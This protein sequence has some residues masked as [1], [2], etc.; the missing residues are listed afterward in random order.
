MLLPQI[1]T[2][3]FLTG[4]ELNRNELFSL[5]EYATVLKKQR[6]QGQSAEHS[7]LLAGKT[8]ALLFE[9]QSLRT[10][11]SFAVAVQQLGGSAIECVTAHAK[12]E[13]PIDTIRV[14]AGYCDAV[15]WR[16]HAH[17]GL[18]KV[19]KKSPISVINGLSDTH[20]P[21]QALADLLT[22]QEKLGRLDGLKLAYVGDGNNMLHSLMLMAPFL[23]MELRY[24]C[25][26]GYGPSAFIVKRAQNRAA[27]G[28]GAIIAAES[29]EQAV[30][31]V[32]AIYTDVWTSMG[33]EDQAKD[34]DAA[35][36]AY[37]VNDDLYRHATPQ[38][39]IMHCMP[40]MR[41]KEITDAMA[42]HPQSVIFQQSENRLHVQKALMAC[43]LK[44]E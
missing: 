10:R 5:L 8:V 4:E 14:L 6:A 2:Q 39:L 22:L 36:Q 33:F 29:P 18:E 34:R 44:K 31:G 9:K 12:K 16:T 13:D 7:S 15:M 40:M 3:H 42:D 26:D 1:E 24:A 38:A 21:C 25:P 23:G 28:R 11:F 43:L 17:R 19:A 27:E 30:Q 37:Q 35:F 41:G 20:H 32:H